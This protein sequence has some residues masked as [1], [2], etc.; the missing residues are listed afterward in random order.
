[1]RNGTSLTTQILQQSGMWLGKDQDIDEQNKPHDPEGVKEN[2]HFVRTNHAILS[3]L[4]TH[5]LD[6]DKLEG[7]LNSFDWDTYWDRALAIRSMAT[8]DINLLVATAE[9]FHMPV[10]GWKDPR[11][12][13][14]LPFWYKMRTEFDNFRIV[15]CIRDPNEAVVS[16]AKIQFGGVTNFDK[17]WELWHI[18]YRRIRRFL[19]NKQADGINYH[20]VDYKD[21][22]EAPG[23][24]TRALA[25]F[26]GLSYTE[27]VL[28]Q[29]KPNLYRHKNTTGRKSDLYQWFLNQQTRLKLECC[30]NCNSF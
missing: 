14:N 15:V 9:V 6:V 27:D 17:L 5:W 24:T 4:K 25:N 10:W 13:L 2:L 3:A 22:F 1:M 29:I 12:S 23:P 26:A 16:M 18:Y 30:Q 8:R 11:N 20:I 21:Y 19:T 28:K 7:K